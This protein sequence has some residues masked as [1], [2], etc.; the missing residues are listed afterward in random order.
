MP[1]RPSRQPIPP[2]AEKEL[3]AWKDNI[4][5]RLKNLE[6]GA[7]LPNSTS[8]G[9]S[10]AW[11]NH[12]L[13]T[14]GYFGTFGDSHGTFEGFVIY[15]GATHSMFMTRAD[16]PGIIHP[17]LSPTWVLD[18]Q[19]IPVT[20]ATYVTVARW[21]PR[22]IYH[23][24]LDTVIPVGS[25]PG[26]VGEIRLI[27]LH[28]GNVTDSLVTT[29]GQ[30]QFAGF[31]WVHPIEPNTGANPNFEIQAKRNSGAGSVNVH[32][33]REFNLT[34]TALVALADTNGYARWVG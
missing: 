13:Q 19:Y 27:E 10:T 15:D 32:Q 28:T 29:A 26:T 3:A 11:K 8:R 20:S 12:D 21:N 9:G 6:T 2:S 1:P 5:R 22:S 25:D 24:V 18:N 34:S 30:F 14:H 4:E 33:S 16:K 7:Q 23:E 31:S 17:E